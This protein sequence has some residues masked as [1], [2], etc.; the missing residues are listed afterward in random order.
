MPKIDK[1]PRIK[2]RTSGGVGDIQELM[3]S[4]DYVDTLA[5]TADFK[6][7]APLWGSWALREAFLAGIDYHREQIRKQS[8]T[9]SPN[10]YHEDY[11]E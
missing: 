3:A 5:D 6:Q 1:A 2:K 7:L 10:Y 11:H 8:V 9:N 4:S